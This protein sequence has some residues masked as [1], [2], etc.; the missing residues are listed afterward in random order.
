MSSVKYNAII[1]VYLHVGNTSMPLMCKGQ[2][3]PI[4]AEHSNRMDAATEKQIKMNTRQSD[5]RIP[6]VAD[7]I[8]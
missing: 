4:Y 7:D 8:G 1:D 2:F 5:W 3:S 6:D